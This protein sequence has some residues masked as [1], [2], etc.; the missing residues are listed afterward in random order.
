MILN[1]IWWWINIITGI[2]FPKIERTMKMVDRIFLVT[3]IYSSIVF[4]IN[5][6]TLFDVKLEEKVYVTNM[7]FYQGT[8]Y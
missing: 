6:T 1:Y 3:A 5:C 4:D 7:I 2:G 8:I